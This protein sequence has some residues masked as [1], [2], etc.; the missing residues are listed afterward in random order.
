MLVGK[1]GSGKSTALQRLCCEE[2]QKAL[3]VI[4]NGQVDFTIPVLVELR[5]RRD[6]SVA[7][8]I[9]K[10]LR[11]VRL[12]EA[13]IEDLLLAGRFLLLFDGLNELPTSDAW[14]ALDEF[15]RD[16]DFCANPRIFTTRELGAGADLGIEKKLEMLPLTEPQ[17]RQFIENRLPG[18][19]ESL[20]RQLKERLRELA[21]T[22]LLLK[23][24][25]DVVQDSPDGQL[26]Q[27]RGEL[28]RQE[29]VRRY[30]K[31]KPSHT[32][33]T[34]GDS[35]R[36]TAEL[37]QHL[38][39]TMIQGDPHTDPCKPTSS[40][41][42]ISK[43][44][45]EKVLEDYLTGRVET[46]AQNAKA[47]LE[48][49]LRFKLLVVKDL[50]HIEF[51]HQLFQEYYAAEKL[52]ALLPTLSH[53]ELKQDYL[54]YLKWTEVIAL[55][56]GLLHNE[57]QAL[58]TVDL[59][60]QVDLRLGARLAGRV[61]WRFQ[62]QAVML[63]SNQKVDENLQNELLGETR[64]SIAETKLLNILRDSTSSSL[65]SA[66]FALGKAGSSL[67]VP[68]LLEL[69]KEL[70]GGLRQTAFNALEKIGTDAA[71]LGLL[72]FVTNNS[73]FDGSYRGICSLLAMDSDTAIPK[74]FKTLEN[75]NH[76]T[77]W[78]IAHIISS[79]VPEQFSKE[80]LKLLY[81]FRENPDPGIQEVI[82]CITNELS[83]KNSHL[84]FLITAEINYLNHTR[85]AMDAMFEKM[86][87]PDCVLKLLDDFESLD[88]MART[89]IA[90]T[91]GEIGLEIAVP[92]LIEALED[93]EP[94]VREA[95]AEALGKINS[96]IAV[97]HLLK[98]LGDED[99][100]VRNA[101][102]KTLVEISSEMAIFGLLTVLRHTDYYV[103]LNAVSA[104]CQIGS[105]LAVPGLIDLLNDLDFTD[106]HEKTVEALENIGNPQ[107]LLTLWQYYKNIHFWYVA[108]SINTIQ[109]RCGFYNY[110]IAQVS[111]EERERKRG[112]FTK[113]SI[114]SN[115]QLYDNILMTIFDS[116]RNIE[117]SPK[118]IRSLDEESLRHILIHAVNAKY[119]N[120]A[121]A[122]AY[123]KGGKTDI[124]VRI[125][126]EKILIAECKIWHGENGLAKALDQLLQRY[127]TWRDT[128][129]ALLIFS[130][131]QKF[132]DVVQ[133]IPQEIKQHQYFVREGNSNLKK[134]WFRFTVCYPDD[135]DRELTLTILA[136]D[137]PS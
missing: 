10:S 105:D 110:E 119:S 20:L 73:D 31:F 41:L 11:R 23:I 133:K 59:S 71:I 98:A 130:R 69:A 29:F 113:S 28:F 5:D 109:N 16:Q 120:V 90:R 95:A 78:R 47:W 79:V 6:G 38:A 35:R 108:K 54:N 9:Q 97:P 91:L 43:T 51:L 67:A 60:L 56:L 106:I 44:K 121:E 25:C 39:F 131:N 135:R 52:L 114:T 46:P 96:D 92:K 125:N 2:A 40:W 61:K 58:Q 18:Q 1:P 115:D 14:A 72:D 4:E 111:V 84:E 80:F 62:E 3:A 53:A 137:I 86:R 104:L 34:S 116:G 74:L 57:T 45:A 65:R 7:N 13:T 129:L 85:P 100:R 136:F 132:S 19:A 21:E 63:V 75:S 48:D 134:A 37:L 88:W 118:E 24:L 64:S 89:G 26:P 36:F 27:N 70:D 50:D 82:T 42:T 17:M 87:S 124:L 81:P 102:T 101:T 68:K 33:P 107:A 103:R 117:S 66:A 99:Y 32:L 12:D 15:Q 49:L 76:D 126:G 112:S 83:K 122:E 55:M 30:E 8:W 77:R 94:S 123:N 128:K 93:L 22:P 127:V